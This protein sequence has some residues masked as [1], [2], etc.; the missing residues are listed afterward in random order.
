MFINFICINLIFILFSFNLYFLFF[1]LCQS[2]G[3]GQSLS[4]YYHRCCCCCWCPLDRCS[5]RV[6]Q[7][8]EKC[9]LVGELPPTIRHLVVEG[10]SLSTTGPLWGEGGGKTSQVSRAWCGFN[11]C[12]RGSCTSRPQSHRVECTLSSSRT[13]ELLSMLSHHHSPH[14]YPRL[15]LCGDRGM[16]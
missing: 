8:S 2:R 10:G 6:G 5:G 12:L 14:P 13:S 15:H 9:S 3:R 1:C 11:L 16:G 4:S 7:E